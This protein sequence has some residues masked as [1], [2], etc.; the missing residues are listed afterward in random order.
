MPRLSEP[1]STIFIAWCEDNRRTKSLSQVLNIPAHFISAGRNLDVRTAPIRYVRQAI[2]T[3]RLLAMKKPTTVVVMLPPI[4]L[5]ALLFCIRPVMRPAVVVDAH[6]GAFLD[7]K[8]TRFGWLTTFLLRRVPVTVVTNPDLAIDL[9]A[10]GI[11]THVVNDPPPFD[12]RMRRVPYHSYVVAPVSYTSDEPIAAILEAAAQLDGLATVVMTGRPPADLLKR[13]PYKNVIFPGF[14]DDAAFLDLIAQASVVLGLTSQTMTV[15]CAANEAASLGRPVVVSRT[16][17]LVA[18]FG[19]AAIYTDNSPTSI[20]ESVK[21]AL[22]EPDTWE[23]RVAAFRRQWVTQ[24]NREIS[25]LRDRLDRIH[26]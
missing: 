8:W 25:G 26:R 9:E 6:S 21:M 11:S 1:G 23:L 10:V 13:G 17:V 24:S 4:P 19:D 15:Q 7:P 3:I 14:L 16:P 2:A 12:P 18:L 5:L 22:A 20:A